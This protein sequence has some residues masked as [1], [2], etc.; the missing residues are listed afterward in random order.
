MTSTIGSQHTA[1]KEGA[2][3][4]GGG[5]TRLLEVTVMGGYLL[6][7]CAS[8]EPF[9]FEMA[10]LGSTRRPTTV[11]KLAVPALRHILT[12]SF[13]TVDMLALVIPYLFAV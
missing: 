7:R 13:I 12:P 9:G 4:G 1:E 5:I 11:N 10:V 3:E 2:R 6:E 8:R